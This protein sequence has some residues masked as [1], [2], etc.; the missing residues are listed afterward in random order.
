MIFNTEQVWKSWY[1]EF[2]FLKL[3][4]YNI[5]CQVVSSGGGR[6]EWMGCICDSRIKWI[7]L[8]VFRSDNCCI[9]VRVIRYNVTSVRRSRRGKRVA[10]FIQNVSVL[11]RIR[12][13]IKEYLWGCLEGIKFFACCKVE[14]VIHLP[15][16][17]PFATAV[18]ISFGVEDGI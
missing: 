4:Q 16:Q 8:D 2:W 15:E 9:S 7:L 3:I 10:Y 11:A 17:K 18:S 1:F 5:S 13:K 6:W 14:S 12:L